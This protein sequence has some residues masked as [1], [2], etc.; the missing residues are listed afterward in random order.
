MITPLLRI[1]FALTFMMVAIAFIILIAAC[2][3]GGVDSSCCDR[4]YRIKE[5]EP[6]SSTPLPV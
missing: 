6:D 1:F 3:S 2:Y 4:F 5:C